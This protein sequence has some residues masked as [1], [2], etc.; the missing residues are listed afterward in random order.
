MQLLGGEENGQGV[1]KTNGNGNGLGPGNG[2]GNGSGNNPVPPGQAK[3]NA[4]VS[5]QAA[6]AANNQGPGNGQGPKTETVTEMEK[7]PK[8]VPPGQ[9]KKYAELRSELLKLQETFDNL[10]G[11]SE[12][13]L[14]NEALGG[15]PPGQRTSSHME[16]SMR[17]SSPNVAAPAS[18]SSEG[19]M[20]FKINRMANRGISGIQQ[21]NSL[22]GQMSLRTNL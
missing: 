22:F 5:S 20:S 17:C 2:P 3:Q 1:N 18:G 4:P 14:V 8:I 12:G 15:T 19:S 6:K 13:S 9:S 16:L 11:R 21:S 10:G 7:G